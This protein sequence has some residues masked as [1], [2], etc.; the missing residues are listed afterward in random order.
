MIAETTSASVTPDA[1]RSAG[2]T[3]T[4]IAGVEAPPALTLAMPGACSRDQ[5]NDLI[6]HEQREV[7]MRGLNV[8]D[9]TTS[10]A[11]VGSPGSKVAVVGVTRSPGRLPSAEATR[12]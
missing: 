11:T 9:V 4:R 6:V 7:G 3:S 8:Y 12:R 10:V 5:G 1:L 2:L